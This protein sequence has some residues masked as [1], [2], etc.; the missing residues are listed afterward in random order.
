M[1]ESTTSHPNPL[2]RMAAVVAGL[3]LYEL[4]PQAVLICGGEDEMGFFYNFL[5]DSPPVPEI[6]VFVKE[7]MKT[8]FS[9]R[10]LFRE[11]EMVAASAAELFKKK[12]HVGA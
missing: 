6:A 8:I 12:G 2:R 7:K 9:M 5:L 10:P 4:L 3:A 11:T 1:F